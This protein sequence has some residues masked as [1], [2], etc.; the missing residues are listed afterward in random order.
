MNKKTAASRGFS[1]VM[2]SV[3]AAAAEHKD[4]GKNDDPGAAV[5]ED[6]AKAVVVIHNEFPPV[7]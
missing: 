1:Y 7:Y 6:V 3:V 4:Q 2:G 5:I